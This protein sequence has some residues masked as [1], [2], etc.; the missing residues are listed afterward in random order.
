MGAYNGDPS[1]WIDEI[2]QFEETDLVQGGPDGVDNIPL[3]NLADRASWLKDQMNRFAGNTIKNASGNIGPGLTGVLTTV[4]A[5][6]GL[7]SVTLESAATF[8]Y[9]AIIPIQS[10]CLPGC[11][12]KLITPA[13]QPIVA[14]IDAG[15]SLASMYMHNREMLYLVALTNHFKV[16]PMHGNFFGAGEEIKSRKVLP[17]TL[18]MDGSLYNRDAYPRLWEYVQSLTFGQQVVSEGAWYYDN[19]TY[20]G[21]YTNG[22]TV[23]TFRVP[24]ER[25]TFDRMLDEGRGLDISRPHNYAGGFEGDA[26]G[27]HTHPVPIPKELTSQGQNGLR[28]ITTGNEANEPSD[29]VTL[30]AISN[31]GVETIVKNIAKINLVKY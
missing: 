12:V 6:A 31:G 10:M 13:G 30:Q 16:I 5:S 23:S 26:V 21:C 4:Q 7:L 9:G 15:G 2:Y 22:D 17:G 20:R 18:K 19:I 28:K 25:G 14:D 3:K 11:A 29:A 1:L 24:D 27:P 8:K